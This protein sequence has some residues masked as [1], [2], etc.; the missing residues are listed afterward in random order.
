MCG[1]GG[2]HNNNHAG[3]GLRFF[4]TDETLHGGVVLLLAIIPAP[5]L[6]TAVSGSSR[7]ELT[8]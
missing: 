3:T 6:T 1:R 2:L 5:V 7:G 8:Y 4:Q